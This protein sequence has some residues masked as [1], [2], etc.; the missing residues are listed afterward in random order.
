MSRTKHVK[1]LRTKCS[2]CDQNFNSN[3]DKNEPVYR[4][5]CHCYNY[6]TLHV[7]KHAVWP[8]N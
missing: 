7:E 3:A 1:A 4:G 2:L 8:Q 5:V 6:G